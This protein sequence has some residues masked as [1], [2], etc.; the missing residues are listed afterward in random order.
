MVS[1]ELAEATA[2]VLIERIRTLESLTTQQ[3]EK[4]QSLEAANKKLSE[5]L[6]GVVETHERLG[7]DQSIQMRRPEFIA[8]LRQALAQYGRT[9]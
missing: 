9:K 3:A 4:I 5:A 1:K 6:K 8:G 2:E 7:A